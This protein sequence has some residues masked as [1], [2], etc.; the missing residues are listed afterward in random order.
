M[1]TLKQIEAFYWAGVLGSFSAA[2]AKLN[3]AQSTISKRLQELEAIL[4][5]RLFDRDARAG[6]LTMKGSELLDMAEQFIQM[7]HFFVAKASDNRTFSGIFRLGV[8]ELIALTSLPEILSAIR[9]NYPRIT[10][11]PHVDLVS[12]L[13]DR[14]QGGTIDLVVGPGIGDID[15]VVAMPF[16]SVKQAWMCSP[17][18][19]PDKAG[20][21]LAQLT[22][23]PLL[24]QPHSSGLHAMLRRF[25]EANGAR[26][27]IVITCNGMLAL[28]KLAA[29]GFGV[30]CLPHFFFVGEIEAGRLRVIDSTPPLPDL[31]FVVAHRKDAVG[32]PSPAVAA[33]I[34]QTGL[35]M[36]PPDALR[37]SA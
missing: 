37:L 11:E 7:Q 19:Y 28:A 18:L 4:Q 36:A 30:T 1:I 3:T 15:N 29:S 24:M 10:V 20:L 34:Q 27:R 16:A 33:L 6:A 25:F 14:L 26:P 21:G 13:Y 32:S 8:T 2:A 17:S 23:L 12:T 31:A 35:A 9:R 5:V 22:E